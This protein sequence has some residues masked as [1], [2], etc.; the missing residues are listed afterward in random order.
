MRSLTNC[1]HTISCLSVTLIGEPIKYVTLF[2][3]IFDPLPAPVTL[4]HTSRTP[5]FFSSTKKQ[6]N[7]PLYKISQLLGAFVPLILSGSFCLKG[8]VRGGFCP[9]PFCQNTSN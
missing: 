1:L 4:C 6:D 2:W 3:T 9:S 8:F 7:Q 5:Q